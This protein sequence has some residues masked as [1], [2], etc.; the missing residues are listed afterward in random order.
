MSCGS[1]HKAE[2]HCV[3]LKEPEIY[4]VY[5]FFLHVASRIAQCA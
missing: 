2:M 5:A 3:L 4:D 1:V